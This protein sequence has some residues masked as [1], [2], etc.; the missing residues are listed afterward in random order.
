MR[1]HRAYRMSFDEVQDQA[2]MLQGGG[3]HSSVVGLLSAVYLLAQHQEAQSLLREEIHERLPPFTRGEVVDPA[4]FSHVPYLDAV[5]N[6]VMRLYSAFSWTGRVPTEPVTV[7]NTM[8]PKGT[9]ISISPWA[10]HRSTRLWGKDAKVFK[11]ERW[12]NG[13]PTVP[14]ELCAFLSF[15]AGPR[16]CIGEEFARAEMK[17]VIAALFGRYRISFGEQS[18]PSVTHQVGVS[19]RAPIIVELEDLGE[20]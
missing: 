9:H 17:C 11:P 6:E 20:W 7:L 5:L 10:L 2:L 14:R 16:N 8:I 1:D 12:L 4:V 18:I 13:A 19:F 3:T 15:L